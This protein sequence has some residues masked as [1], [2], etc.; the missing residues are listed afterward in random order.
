MTLLRLCLSFSE[1]WPASVLPLTQG[2]RPSCLRRGKYPRCN[3][4]PRIAE[5]GEVKVVGVPIGTDAYVMESV[6]ETVEN[7]GAE[8]LARMP[9]WMPDK[10]SAKRIATGSMVQQTAYYIVE[11][12]MNPEL[13][14]CLHV[15]I[16]TTA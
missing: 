2:K 7:G 4:L 5:R 6:M 11:R 15:K 10:Q 12:V 1:T 3:K 8:Q 14:L 16:Q 9:P 13:S